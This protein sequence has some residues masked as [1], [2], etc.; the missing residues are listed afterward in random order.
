LQN[1]WKEYWDENWK[2]VMKYLKIGTIDFTQFKPYYSDG[3][4]NYANNTD[5]T[6]GGTPYPEL[7][8]YYNFFHVDELISINWIFFTYLDNL[9]FLGGLLD[10]ALFI[11]SIIMIG[12]TFRL[13]EINVFFY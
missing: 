3:M 6:I 10:I 5:V 13:N 4:N 11:P 9:S 8:Q 1:N 12:Y 7:I 2:P